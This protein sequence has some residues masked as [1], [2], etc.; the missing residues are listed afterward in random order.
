MGLYVAH[1][2]AAHV[3]GV[4]VLDWRVVVATTSILTVVGGDA[5]AFKCTLVGAVDEDALKVLV[6]RF[7]DP[8]GGLMYPDECVSACLTREE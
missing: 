7:C 1:Y 4:E 6:H 2:V 3:D 5:N 8:K